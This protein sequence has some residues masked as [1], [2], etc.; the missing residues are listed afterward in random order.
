[1]IAIAFIGGLA[2]FLLGMHILASGLQK[3]AGS[4]MKKLL[5]ILTKNRFTSVLA[6]IIVTAI[7]QSSSA[8]TVMVIGFVNAGIMNL[9][10]AC[11]VI[12]GANIGTTVTS[13]IVSS[14]EWAAFLNPTKSAS[15][16]LGFG[17]FLL[18]FAKSTRK[19]KIGEILAGFG[20]LF[21]GIAAMSKGVEPLRELPLFRE[22]FVTFGSNPFLGILAGALITAIIQSSSA[23]V[24]ILQSLAA[25]GLIPFNSAVYIIMGQNIGTCI[26]A[27]LSS[28]GASKSAKCAAY[29]HLLFNVFGTLIFTAISL[30]FF[31]VV[32]PSFGNRF[33]TQTE[34][35]F[36]HAMFN[37]L[38]TLIL[39]PLPN[40]LITWAKKI[41]GIKDD[42]S[43]VQEAIVHLDDR[44]L[45]TPA[46]AIESV[47]K[48]AIRMG[49]IVK[50]ALESA[51]LALTS[52]SHET[53]DHV[54]EQENIIDEME[55]ALTEFLI[56]ISK[57]EI[58]NTESETVSA[59]VHSITDFERIGDH[60]EN[61]AEIAQSFLDE[62]FEMSPDALNELNEMYLHTIKAY[63]L[64]LNAFESDSLPIARQVAAEEE[65]VDELE[66]ALRSSHIRRLTSDKCSPQA[67]V[68]FLDTII[69]LERISDHSRNIAESILE[70]ALQ[71]KETN[72]SPDLTK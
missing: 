3:F 19:Q 27:L 28:I 7:I 59:L 52:K 34:I 9:V 43:L 21:M 31:A 61:L 30:L 38:S 25:V 72:P 15:I 48:E 36:V 56:K 45:E 16:I 54:Y 10:Q 20:L 57:C 8:T 6:G 51:W 64:A 58:S 4:K 49:F 11:G 41:A 68:I 29:I 60:S 53:I 66:I 22:M 40:L 50:E 44:M 13:F 47:K 37:I 42:A 1:M 69:N 2:Q 71:H 17:V 70:L 39:F 14:S 62:D 63:N 46:F 65:K 55:S 26:T 32:G 67:G 35:S 18:L 33:I 5:G 12:M 24:G 23:S